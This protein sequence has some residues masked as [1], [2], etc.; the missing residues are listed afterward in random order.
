MILDDKII[1]ICD[2]IIKKYRTSEF[3]IDYWVN[4]VR[5][6]SIN[7]NHTVI[8]KFDIDKKE[9]TDYPRKLNECYHLLPVTKYH[10]CNDDEERDLDLKNYHK[11]N[12]DNEHDKQYR[13]LVKGF[14]EMFDETYY[15]GYPFDVL[16]RECDN[17]SNAFNTSTP[18]MEFRY[19][20]H[21]STVSLD[22]LNQLIH[23][24]DI[25]AI[26]LKLL[27]TE[28]PL[29]VKYKSNIRGVPVNMY[30]AVAAR[31]TEGDYFV[32]IR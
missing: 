6:S 12:S 10:Y 30:G 8:L 16:K 29:F 26:Y 13:E 20:K 22:L 1:K 23:G 14:N 27:E 24:E 9:L 5:I 28:H 25:R 32:R 7:I 19:L 2:E 3:F 4:K 21:H 15:A 18:C 17:I 31:I 11:Y